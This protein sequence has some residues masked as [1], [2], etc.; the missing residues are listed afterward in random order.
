MADRKVIQLEDG[1]GNLYDVKDTEARA[2]I[3]ELDEN[4]AEIDGYY[5]ELT[6]GSA[7]QLI[8]SVGIHDK[9][10]YVFRTAG[11]SADIGNRKNESIVGGT[12]CWNQLNRELV[13][14][15]WR[16]ADATATYNND[17]VTFTASA[18]YGRI[19]P[20]GNAY[21]PLIVTDHKY[22]FT[23]MMKTAVADA[24]VTFG[25]F[26][27]NQFYLGKNGVSTTDWVTITKIVSASV[28]GM[29]QITLQDNATSG[30]GEVQGKNIMFFDLTQMFGS[31][32][33]DYIYSLEQATAGAGVAWFRKLFPK[34][35]YAYN[36]GEL[37]SAKAAAMETIGFNQWDEEWEPGNINSAGNN[38]IDS[39]SIRSKNFIP[40]LPNTAYYANLVRATSKW[41]LQVWFY[42]GDKKLIRS[43]YCSKQVF[44][45]PDNA[46]YLRI[47]TNHDVH[48]GTVYQNDICINL[49]WDG[50]RNG[51]Y[52]AYIKRTY[53]LDSSLEL[54][55]V[56]KLDANNSLYYD[57][58][59]YEP[60]GKVTRK[61]GV[62]DLGTLSWQTTSSGRFQAYLSDIAI[63][64]SGSSK[65]Q[66]ICTKYQNITPSD[67]F[68]K[69]AVG[70][71]ALK[72]GYVGDH[73]IGIYDPNYEEA[74]YSAFKAA[75]SGVYLVYELATPTTE[76]AEPFQ[77]PQI[78]DDFGTERFI[79]AAYEAEDRDV[80]IPVGHETYYQANLRAKL[81]MAP[82]SPD[83]NGDYIVRQTN[84][85]N[86]YVPLVIPTELPTA[87]S[88]NGT[89]TLKVTVANGTP[90]YSWVSG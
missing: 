36:A 23:G 65:V 9:D 77:D 18:R 89:Y 54:R 87:P 39:E 41:F 66:L 27:G 58:D 69:N 57:G 20:N 52:E 31:T 5:E 13:S 50:E 86:E 22:L 17:V 48:Y 90:T 67:W 15:Y 59:T 79:D 76:E 56:P 10:P 26:T 49:S 14:T 78:V 45:T 30:W 29:A 2:G 60:D 84:G 19:E 73:Y 32:I 33:A 38:T 70:I 12:V 51:E 82:N 3:E 74:D 62:V 63:P 16:T 80:E 53:P 47:S 8:A 88:E 61:Y 37:M 46:L 11:G 34:P 40:C 1:A 81:E 55:G 35:Y 4:K 28:T 68:N 43:G 75:M 71:S 64:A 83:G 42:D 72:S 44:T 85:Q 7:E 24:K 6:A 21:R 25:L